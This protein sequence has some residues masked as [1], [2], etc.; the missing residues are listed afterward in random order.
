MKDEDF[1]RNKYRSYI[2]LWACSDATKKSDRDILYGAIL[3][4]GRVLEFS[5]KKIHKDMKM[6]SDKYSKPTYH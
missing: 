4:L 1:T 5:G 2:E 6:A 3:A